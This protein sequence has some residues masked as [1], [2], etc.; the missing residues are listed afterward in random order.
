MET[1]QYKRKNLTSFPFFAVCH[2]F[3]KHMEK[4]LGEKLLVGFTPGTFSYDIFFHSVANTGKKKVNR[5]TPREK[6]YRVI[7][8]FPDVRNVLIFTSKEVFSQIIFL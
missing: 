8:F 3:F 4:K 1:L 7:I 5:L 6:N 2:F